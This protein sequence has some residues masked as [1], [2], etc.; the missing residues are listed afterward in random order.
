[1]KKSE[2]FPI[3]LVS[4]VGVGEESGDL[5]AMLEKIAEMYEGDVDASVSGLL[6]LLEPAI[7]VFLGA[8]VGGI[9]ICLFLPILKIPQMVS[10][11]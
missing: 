3:M 11:Q 9:V 2:F 4:M 5:P 6:S 8:V 1:M 7:M 10:G